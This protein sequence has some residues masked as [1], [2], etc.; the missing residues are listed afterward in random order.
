MIFAQNKRVAAGY[1]DNLFNLY[2]SPM[3]V[4]LDGISWSL[5]NTSEA[6]FLA[7]RATHLVFVMER[8]VG[9][10]L[11]ATERSTTLLGGLQTV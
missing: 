10:L 8:P 5:T 6:R 11:E 4:S 9:L 3:V 7:G 1:N 2:P